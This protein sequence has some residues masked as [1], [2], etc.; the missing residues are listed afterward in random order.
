[1]AP[2]TKCIAMPSRVWLLWADRSG[3]GSSIPAISPKSD[4]CCKKGD[5]PVPGWRVRFVIGE[6][7][8][9]EAYRV[10]RADGERG[11][12]KLYP[13]ARAT[14]RG[15]DCDATPHGEINILKSLNHPGIPRVLDTG[16]IGA[17]SRPYVLLE[18]VP[19]E[20]LEALL[21][22]NIALSPGHAPGADAGFDRD[23]G[24]T[25][26]MGRPGRAQSADPRPCDR[27]CQN[28]GDRPRRPRG[29]RWCPAGE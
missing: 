23:R 9:T 8:G 4:P 3:A 24:P 17:D 27:R 6:G 18:L 12:L 22:R 29:L 21:T 13:P 1:M 7:S 15:P 16:E 19:G 11:L 28:R 2:T 20:T 25:A 10:R 14:S 5:E 26:P